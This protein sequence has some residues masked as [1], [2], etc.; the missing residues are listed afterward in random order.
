MPCTGLSEHKLSELP[1]SKGSLFVQN[2]FLAPLESGS[3]G[4]VLFCFFF[5]LSS[6]S[7]IERIEGRL[8]VKVK[9][10]NY[11]GEIL[12]CMLKRNGL[13]NNTA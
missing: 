9:V 13:S 1:A 11:P 8:K 7:G 5:F 12:A 4:C 3:V 10:V 2:L 6:S